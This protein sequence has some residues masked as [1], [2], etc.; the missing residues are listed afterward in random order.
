MAT[1]TSAMMENLLTAIDIIAEKK[2]ESLPYDKTLLCTIVSANNAA[3]GEYSVTDGTSTFLAYSDNTTYKENLRVYVTVPNGDF[4][5]RKII[6][7]KYV[8]GEGEY[9]TYVS[10]LDNFLDITGNI[11]GYRNSDETNVAITN[12]V[13]LIANDIVTPEIL[14]WSIG[15]DSTTPVL[16]GH[17]EQLTELNLSQYT[18]LGLGGSFITRLNN[19]IT[20]QYGLRLE[21]ITEV[22]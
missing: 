10:P 19:V 20:G 16:G 17:D 18:R 13:G 22:A 15:K 8:S 21:V 9:Y 12:K 1:D 5:N 2:V 4:N 7:G 11:Y 6:K 3:R 14:L